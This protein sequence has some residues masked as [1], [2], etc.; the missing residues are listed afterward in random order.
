MRR[1]QL[2][3]AKPGVH[4]Y[5]CKCDCSL[6]ATART[7]V[8]HLGNWDTTKDI[9]FALVGGEEEPKY[10]T[11]E[12]TPGTKKRA[13]DAIDALN[14]IKFALD[15]PALST[16]CVHLHFVTRASQVLPPEFAIS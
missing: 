1:G 4:A 2:K 14:S 12:F 13:Q 8:Q 16:R 11:Y 15:G 3:F 5:A 10:V 6:L 7:W 9:T